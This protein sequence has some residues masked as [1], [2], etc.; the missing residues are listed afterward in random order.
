[1]HVEY[2][3]AFMFSEHKYSSVFQS[4]EALA[5][6]RGLSGRE[7]SR[8]EHRSRVKDVVSAARAAGVDEDTIGWAKRILRDRNDKPLWKQIHDLVLSTG[9]IGQRVL[10]AS[11]DFGPITAG[12]RTGVSH[13]GALKKLDPVGRVWH[14]EVLRWVVRARILMD[15]GI[16][17]EEVERRVLSRGAFNR[18]VDEIRTYFNDLSRAPD[19]PSDPTECA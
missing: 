10:E 7:K 13:G 8:A 4:A 1:M 17:F 16:P 6:A 12:A 19:S 18:T 15:L 5:S 3:T 2:Y 11:P 9:K 14:G